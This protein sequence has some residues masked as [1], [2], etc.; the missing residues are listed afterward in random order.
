MQKN[1]SQQEYYN[2]S[3][4]IPLDSKRDQV[5]YEDVNDPNNRKES[6]SQVSLHQKGIKTARNVV[7]GINDSK[8]PNE[9][10]MKP[11]QVYGVSDQEK[12]I[13]IEDKMYDVAESNKYQVSLSH[14]KIKMKPNMVYGVGQSSDGPE[15]S[16]ISQKRANLKLKKAIQGTDPSGKEQ[17]K[18]YVN[19][20][21]AVN[22]PE[23]ESALEYD[24]V[25]K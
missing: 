18:D 15:V 4:D 3:K 7:Y 2:V 21:M 11:N 23:D 1:S 12:E 20:N 24:Y 6:Q 25:D 5:Y 19:K 13:R 16:T 9:I 14:N 10:K 22:I 8:N 17:K